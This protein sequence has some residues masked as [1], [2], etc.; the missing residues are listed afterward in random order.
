V[1]RRPLAGADAD[2]LAEMLSFV[3]EAL[4]WLLEAAPASVA[5]AL[6]DELAT[7]VPVVS[8]GAGWPSSVTVN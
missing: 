5:V 1:G 7:A 6:V 2:V 8:P 4:G 3:V